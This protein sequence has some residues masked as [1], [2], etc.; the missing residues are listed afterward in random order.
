MIPW[1]D[2]T[3][4]GTPFPDP[5]TAL[6]EPDGLLAAG[7]SLRPLRLLSAYRRG[8]FPWYNPGEPVLWWAPSQR[9][10][11]YPEQIHIPRRLQRE[12]R[13][14]PFEISHNKA[15]RDVMIACAAPRKISE[16]SWISTEMID[17]YCDLHVLGYAR[18]IECYLNNKLVGG[19]YGVQL[20]QVF[21]GESMFHTVSNASK[22]VLIETAR[23]P[24]I[25]LI[26]CQIPNPHLESMGMVMVPRDEFLGLLDEFCEK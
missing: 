16:A 5:Q 8:I 4:D 22:A 10:V 17:A 15:F 20:G 13:K 9:A 19:I 11:I 6:S 2:E 7:G 24:D 14:L 26:D 12:L 3:D 21:F 23:Q 25:A 18:S 1:L